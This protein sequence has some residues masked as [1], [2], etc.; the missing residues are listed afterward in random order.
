MEREIEGEGVR[1]REGGK[2]VGWFLGWP[3]EVDLPRPSKG[4]RWNVQLS[5][6]GKKWKL[7]RKSR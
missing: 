7:R 3:I 5:K 2:E 6:V 4:G 1:G